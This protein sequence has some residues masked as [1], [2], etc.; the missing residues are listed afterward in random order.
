MDQGDTLR[1]KNQSRYDKLMA[2]IDQSESDYSDIN[3]NET[4]DDSY[5]ESDSYET[6][7]DGLAELLG[8]AARPL[9]DQRPCSRSG[10]APSTSANSIPD[11][12]KY[13]QQDENENTSRFPAIKLTFRDPVNISQFKII[14][15]RRSIYSIL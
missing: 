6:M 4:E 3:D 13:D 7:S 2:N 12:Q 1:N 10:H 11:F 8:D 9:D 14:Q 5:D 15:V